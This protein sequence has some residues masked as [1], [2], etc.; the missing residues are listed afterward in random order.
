MMKIITLKTTTWGTFWAV[1]IANIYK[2]LYLWSFFFSFLLRKPLL[3]ATEKCTLKW[4]AWKIADRGINEESL[5]RHFSQTSTVTC[6]SYCICRNSHWLE[7]FK[8]RLKKLLDDFFFWGITHLIRSEWEIVTAVNID[9]NQSD[10]S[11]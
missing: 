1:T 11:V 3:P 10:Y 5:A 2:T 4:R 6:L 7:T 9:F 8:G